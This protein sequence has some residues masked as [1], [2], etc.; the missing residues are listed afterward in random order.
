MVAQ[1]WPCYKPKYIIVSNCKLPEL[2][3]SV[4]LSHL[5]FSVSYSQE[6]IVLYNHVMHHLLF[7]G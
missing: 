3:I 1:F 6:D 2:R 5:S 7:I 4:L